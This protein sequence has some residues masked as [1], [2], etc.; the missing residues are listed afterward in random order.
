MT[1]AERKETIHILQEPMQELKLV[2]ASCG[3][4]A[5]LMSQR[6]KEALDIAVEV[7]QKER[8]TPDYDALDEEIA[9][10]EKAYSPLPGY[11]DYLSDYYTRRGLHMAR[12]LIE[13]QKKKAEGKDENENVHG[14]DRNMGTPLS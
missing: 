9:G 11:D 10:Y 13:L 8:L 3:G 4:I 5:V 7:L 1:E 6:L 2:Q 14:S 12:K